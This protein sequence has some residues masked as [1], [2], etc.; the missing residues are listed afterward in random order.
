MLAG[1]Q[2]IF[3]GSVLDNPL[4]SVSLDELKQ[5]HLPTGN[6][7]FYTAPLG[8]LTIDQIEQ[9]KTLIDELLAATQ[10]PTAIQTL[11]RAKVRLSQRMP[12][13]VSSSP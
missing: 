7:N 3:Q 5:T 1:N 6:Q 11:Q 13:V 4:N 12:Q 9:R 8:A 2:L 10:D